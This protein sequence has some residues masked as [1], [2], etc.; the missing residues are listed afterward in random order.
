MTFRDSS[1]PKSSFAQFHEKQV[2]LYLCD[3]KISP[4]VGTQHK[5]MMSNQLTTGL[6]REASLRNVKKR[7]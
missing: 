7:A 3:T 1:G 5:H 4:S 6:K 2:R